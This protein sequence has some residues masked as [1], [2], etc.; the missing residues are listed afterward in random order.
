[1]ADLRTWL[2][3]R[4]SLG[5]ELG[6]VVGLYITYETV[7][8]IFGGKRSVALRHAGNVVSVERALHVFV[9][10]SVQR[11]A[12]AVPHLAGALGIAYLLVHLGITSAVLLW[13][14]Q[15]RPRAYPF[16]RTTLL[17][18]GG[19][20]V[21]GYAVFPTA[22]P[23]LSGLGMLDPVASLSSVNLNRGLVSAL[24][25]PYAAMPSMHA[26]YALVVG[27]AL[28][29]QGRHLLT[30]LIGIAY[31]AFVVFVIVATG[32]HFLLDAAAGALVA[33]VAAAGTALLLRPRPGVLRAASVSR[34]SAAEPSFVRRV[35]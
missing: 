2:S 13:L 10:S 21:V 16:F 20:A 33:V 6:L 11:S 24:Y 12:E 3:R 31:P 17:V 7:R 18:S 30:R 14:H 34:V 35:A 23:R 26:G 19:L 27:V 22:P 28:L 8:G 1:M 4:H 32:N 29:T 9:E 15:R 5:V 25:D